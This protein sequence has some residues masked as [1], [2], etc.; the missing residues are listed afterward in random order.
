M[1]GE[2]APEGRGV[3]G[4]P[5]LRRRFRG[6]GEVRIAA[7]T[8]DPKLVRLLDA[9]LLTLGNTGRFDILRA[10]KLH[11]LRPLEVWEQ[12]RTG[13]VQN[14]PSEA[15]FKVLRPAWDR[16]AGKLKVTDR[17]RADVRGYGRRLA[18]LAGRN[19]TVREL[20]KALL[21][22]RESCEKVKTPVTF[23]R[24]R[25]ACQAFLRDV[26]GRRSEIYGA[27]LEIPTLPRGGRN[28]VGGQEPAEAIAAAKKLP[29]PA[30]VA[31]LAMCLTGM[32]PG[33]LAGRWEREG[34]ALHIHG[35]KREHR[36]RLVPFLA[37]VPRPTLTTHALQEAMRKATIGLTPYVGRRTFAH[38]MEAAKIP[39]ARRQMYMGHAPADTLALY[40]EHDVRK[41]LIE[42]AALLD[43]YLAPIWSELTNFLTSATNGKRA[44]Q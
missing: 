41:F 27:V 34:E 28:V 44:A 36:N 40:E 31:W 42:D 13:N 11:R 29:R 20:P 12:Y 9:M 10:L 4:T 15:A 22:F 14:L 21:A 37:D 32:G 18:T 17:Y 7:G 19:P 16:W 30:A 43:A 2:S 24:A 8:S 23:N 26:A 39:R 1:A 35:T 6:L 5:Q 33:E 25:S 38:W 3:R